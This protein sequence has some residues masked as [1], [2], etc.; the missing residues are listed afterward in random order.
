V[1]ITARIFEGQAETHGL[2]TVE[3]AAV[4]Y[5]SNTK[6]LYEFIRRRPWLPVTRLGRSIFIDPKTFE[7]AVTKRANEDRDRRERE[8]NRRYFRRAS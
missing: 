2:L 4:R 1:S 7:A 6:A 5:Q 8:R 3:Q